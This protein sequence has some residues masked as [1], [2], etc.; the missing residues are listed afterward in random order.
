M[1]K[2]KLLNEVVANQIAA[3]EVVEGPSSVVKE[4]IENSQDAGASCIEI[5]ADD[6][7]KSITIIDDGCGMTAE[8]AVL[9]FSRYATSKI[10]M[11]DDLESL[12]TFGFRGE[13]LAS[14]ASVAQVTLITRQISA[15]L[16]TKVQVVGGKIVDVGSCGGA[17][18][19]RIEIRDLF[20]NVPARKKF[21]KSDRAELSAIETAVQAMALSHPRITFK[22]KVEDKKSIEF[23]KVNE[24]DSIFSAAQIDRAV[25]IL[26]EQTRKFIYPF[27]DKTHHLDISGFVVAPLHTRRDFKGIMLYVNNRLV[28]DRQLANAVKVAFRSLLEVG[29]IPVC[30]LNFTIDPKSIDVNVHP[31]KLEVRFSD[32]PQIC[33]EIIRSLSRFLAGTPWLHAATPAEFSAQVL[34]Q[35]GDFYV[36]QENAPLYFSA[37]SQPFFALSPAA[38]SSAATQNSAHFTPSAQPPRLH[39]HM[40]L[41]ANKKFSE[42]RIIGQVGSTFL[43]LEGQNEMIVVDQHAAHER[44]LFE[45]FKARSRDAAAQS[46]AMLLPIQLHLNQAEMLAL[47][48]HQEKLA[49]FGLE[50]RPLGERVALIAGIP[51]EVTSDDAAELVLN[52]LGDLAKHGR[53]DSWDDFQDKILASMACHSAV[54]AGQKLKDDE[55]AALLSQLEAI[56]YSAHCPHGRPLV[57]SVPMKEIARWFDRP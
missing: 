24:D 25:T 27:E 39:T 51:V 10:S 53:A 37:K 11:I 7:G 29:R 20:F 4:L 30:A 54:R 21:L 5:F 49:S 3:G 48:E 6:G 40:G 35:S 23:V 8:D 12:Q 47:S 13:A 55:I 1:S 46:Q 22:L 9:C 32:G 14:I 17:F 15:Q 45:K 41:G 52:I 36:Q 34:P 28:R 33:S 2:I 18:G 44:I 43:V 42:L 26:G 57:R 56:D 31:Q 16:A 38:T 50:V 19:T